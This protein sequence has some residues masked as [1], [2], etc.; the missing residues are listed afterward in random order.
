[1][2]KGITIQGQ[3]TTDSDNGTANDQTVLVDNLVQ[4]P[5]G[6]GFF[7]CTANAGQSLRIT[8]I[9]FSGVGG[10]NDTLYNG[11]VRFFGTS[12]HVRIDHCHFTALS[13]QPQIQVNSTVYGV[14]DHNVFDN[15]IFQCESHG[16][17]NGTGEGDLEFT[18]PAGYGG[19]KFFFVEDCYINNTRGNHSADGGFD[20]H[21]GGK[22][23]VRH[24]HLFNV[25]ILCH[26][27]R[28]NRWRGGRAQELYNNDYHWSYTTTM[29]GITSGSLIAHDNTYSGVLPY[30]Y[31]L[32]TYRL[33][34]LY[35]NTPWFGASGDNPWDV[36]VTEPDGTHVDG[37]P[38]YLFE[39]GTATDGSENCPAG[40]Q[41]LT[42]TSKNWT[43]NQ[44]AG[45]T[46]RRL[47]DNWIGQIISNTSNTLTMFFYFSGGAA[48]RRGEQAI[49]IKSI[50]C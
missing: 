6:Q 39:S 37:H 7:H 1:M 18:Q 17:Y 9:T 38:P 41:Y 8:R 35:P 43:T 44:W 31:G 23:V 28:P 42:D 34:T 12:D 2:T 24:C 13:H 47:S 22:Y 5:G 20:A 3:T 48:H 33:F 40:L 36:N 50:R 11:A 46:A 21:G 19:S 45:Y 27:T 26:M 30:G 32:Q 15:L 29:D 49:S 25:E 16:V 10:R 14:S 4:V